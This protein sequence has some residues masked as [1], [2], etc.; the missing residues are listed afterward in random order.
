MLVGQSVDCASACFHAVIINCL[1]QITDGFGRLIESIALLR[2]FDPNDCCYCLRNFCSL[3]GTSF[4]NHE[5]MPLR[6]KMI[7]SNPIVTDLKGLKFVFCYWW[8]FA[9][10]SI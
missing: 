9:I 4:K 3:D 6:L 8:T 1:A 5:N 10:P 7:Q 2:R